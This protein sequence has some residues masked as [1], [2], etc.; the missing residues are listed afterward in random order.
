[1]SLLMFKSN[2]HVYNMVYKSEVGCISEAGLIEVLK[3][4]R[5]SALYV[6]PSRR[7]TGG[8]W[9]RPLSALDRCRIMPLGASRPHRS[10]EADRALVQY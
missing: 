9:H 1:M 3:L 5:R 7:Q 2:N 10:G 6:G 8:R 4:G